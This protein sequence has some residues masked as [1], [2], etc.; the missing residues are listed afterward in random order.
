MH[1]VVCAGIKSILDIPKSLEVLESLSVPVMTYRSPVFPAFYTNDS[2]C[3]S[4]L[5]TRSCEEVASM[6][7]TQRSMGLSAGLLVAVPNPHPAGMEKTRYAVDFALLSAANEGITGAAVTPYVLDRVQRLTDGESLEANVAL[8]QHNALVAARIAIAYAKL[9]R[10]NSHLDDAA[11]NSNSHLDAVASNSNQ[12]TVHAASASTLLD[13]NSTNDSPRSAESLSIMHDDPTLSADILVVGASVI[14]LIGTLS[15]STQL[16]SS[17]P[18]RVQISNGGVGRNIAQ[19]L[20]ALGVRVKLGSVVADDSNGRK[21]LDDC[22]TAGV[23]T[24]LI[25]I[26]SSSSSSN[27]QQQHRTAVYSAIHDESG[28]LLVGVADTTIMHQLDSQYVDDVLANHLTRTSGIEVLVLDGNLS[29]DTFSSLVSTASRRG[30]S[31]FFEPTS[32][33]KCL[34][35]LLAGCFHQVR[36]V[37]QRITYHDGS[38]WVTIDEC[39]LACR[40]TSSS[41]MYTS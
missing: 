32:S 15:V 30:V 24:S 36:A 18:G 3:A 19:S 38:S 21:L 35:P 34:L 17:N 1:V 25:K 37:S 20:A 39:L 22:R 27:D 6:M 40:S 28:D 41:R 12:P 29:T 14:D 26:M 33:H 13:Q 16:K 10:S 31:L 23:D 9:L 11:S 5:V 2:G 4:P 8:I 7:A